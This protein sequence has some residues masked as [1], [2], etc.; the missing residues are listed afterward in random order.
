MQK[1]VFVCSISHL[2]ECLVPLRV[3]VG[4]VAGPEM[5]RHAWKLAVLFLLFPDGFVQRRSKG[6]RRE[7]DEKGQKQALSLQQSR[8]ERPNLCPIWAKPQH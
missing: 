5:Q 6:A 8:Q 4:V 7:A 3:V 1:G 2:R